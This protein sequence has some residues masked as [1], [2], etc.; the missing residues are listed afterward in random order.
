MRLIM[1]GVYVCQLEAW[2]SSELSKESDIHFKA[3]DF[4]HST[5][6]RLQSLTRYA[7]FAPPLTQPGLV[8]P[9]TCS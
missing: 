9:P 5:P 7:P 1:R 6:R 3:E 8:Q 2:E 4:V